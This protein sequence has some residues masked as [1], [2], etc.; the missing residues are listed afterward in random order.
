MKTIKV[1]QIIKVE[2][3]FPVFCF[4]FI[5][6]QIVTTISLKR[7][8]LEQERKCSIKSRENYVMGV[9]KYLKI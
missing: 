5:F 7:K 9:I 8:L 6:K 4:L 1:R 2:K 3:L